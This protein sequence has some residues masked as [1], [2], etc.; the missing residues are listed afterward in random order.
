MGLSK[1]AQF[2]IPSLETLTIGIKNNRNYSIYTFFE[3]LILKLRI[4]LTFINWAARGKKMFLET[5]SSDHEHKSKFGRQLNFVSHHLK[6][7]HVFS[8]FGINKTPFRGTGCPLWLNLLM[9]LD[10]QTLERYLL[11]RC[12]LRKRLWG[13]SRAYL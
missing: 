12:M 4:I 7:G 8:L 5:K 13:L 10:Y 11:R 3:L 1:G 6:F 2:E 9:R